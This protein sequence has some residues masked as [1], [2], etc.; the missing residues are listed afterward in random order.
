M[1]HF[2]KRCFKCG[3]VKGISEFYKHSKRADEYLGKCKECRSLYYKSYRVK[4]IDRCNGYNRKYQR[5][6]RSIEMARAY[7][8]TDAG[9]Q[10]HCRA[11][12]NYRKKNPM[13]R[14][15]C[16]LINNAL[17]DDRIK[18]LP[19]EICGCL[20]V[21]AHHSNYKEPF[22]VQWLCAQ[23]HAGLHR[24]LRRNQSQSNR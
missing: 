24:I 1:C 14:K 22:N 23:H 21:H 3:I 11:A 20:K 8:E 16:H 10:A 12:S 19:C 6:P 5:L 2:D 4:H 17:R 9:K 7:R 18:K 13:K 15:V